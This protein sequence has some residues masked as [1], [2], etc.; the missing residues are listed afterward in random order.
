VIH[1]GLQRGSHFC[2]LDI[3]AILTAAKKG[4]AKKAGT[5]RAGTKKAAKKTVSLLRV[6]SAALVEAGHLCQT[7]CLIAT[8]LGLAPYCVMGLADSLIGRELGI[9]G[10]TKVRDL[11]RGSGRKPARSSWASAPLGIFPIRRIRDSKTR[12]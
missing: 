7:F 6:V 11:C 9:D 4:A 12:G 2:A 8:W 3:L 5:K 1:C 10:L